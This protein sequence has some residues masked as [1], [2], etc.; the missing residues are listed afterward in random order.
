MLTFKQYYMYT[1]ATVSTQFGSSFSKYPIQ[2]LLPHACGNTAVLC[3][4]VTTLQ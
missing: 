4:K 3:T 1:I 2:L